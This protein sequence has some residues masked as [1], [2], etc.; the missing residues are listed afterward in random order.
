MS[1]GG[2]FLFIGVLALSDVKQRIPLKKPTTYRQQI[3]LLLSRG[4]VIHDIDKAINILK[5]VSYYR[6]TAYGLSLKQ[7]EDRYLPGTTFEQIYRLYEFDSKLRALLLSISEYVE[8]SFRT[9][10]IYYLAHNYGE[11]GYREGNH[12]NP[13]L[14]HPQ[15]LGKLDK[16]LMDAKEL[17]ISHHK[18]KYSGQFPAWAAFEVMTFGMLST[19][20]KNLKTSDKK[21]IAKDYYDVNYYNKIT[22]WLHS[23]SVLRNRCAH[24]SR[25]YN[26]ALSIAPSLPDESDHLEINN[27]QL[28]SIVYILK[29]LVTD[30]SEW[31]TWVT[32]LEALIEAYPEIDLHLLGFKQNWVGILRNREL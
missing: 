12:F 2:A 4:V 7:E 5:R 25:I 9:H 20:Y 3:E 13:S 32:Q 1:Q 30:Q 28:F 18:N 27:N 23:I 10:L 15:F 17:F 31:V 22:T 19:L 11:L 29:K 16:L 26:K 21:R 6:F 24:Y 14:N 8:I